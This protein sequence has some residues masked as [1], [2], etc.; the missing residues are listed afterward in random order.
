[1]MACYGQN[2]RMGFE[3]P[4]NKTRPAYQALQARDVN[5]IIN[6]MRDI[7]E[8]IREEITWAQALQQEYA[9]CKR[10]PALAYEASDEV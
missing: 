7:T 4:T 9:N 6:K 3:P 8:F 2:P 5:V 1:M 10:L